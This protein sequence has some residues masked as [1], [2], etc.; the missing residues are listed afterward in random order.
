M[1]Q[2]RLAWNEASQNL[3]IGGRNGSFPGMLDTIKFNVVWVSPN[4]GVSEPPTAAIDKSISYTGVGLTL[5]KTTGAISSVLTRPN[6]PRGVSLSMKLLGRKFVAKPTGLGAD[7]W[8]V[9]LVNSLGKIIAFK[10]FNGASACVVA[11]RLT[12]GIYFAR[13][14]YGKNLMDKQTVIVP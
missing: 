8:Q 3:S 2:F 11:E 6:L 12:S 13:S 7:I 10:E 5:N 1:P 14:Y 4:H 9:R